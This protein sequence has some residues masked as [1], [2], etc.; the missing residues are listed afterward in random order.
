[1]RDIIFRHFYEQKKCDFYGQF[2]EFDKQIP[3]S[4][5]KNNYLQKIT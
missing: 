5:P 3:Y 1:M 2:S 4:E